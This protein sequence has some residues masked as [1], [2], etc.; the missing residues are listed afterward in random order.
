MTLDRVQN[1][2]GLK[3]VHLTTVLFQKEASRQ[4]NV[5]PIQ[6]NCRSAV[7][8]TRIVDG[9]VDQVITAEALLQR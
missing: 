5:V 6:R 1:S 7:T 2:S 4:P 3:T 8:K 9:G